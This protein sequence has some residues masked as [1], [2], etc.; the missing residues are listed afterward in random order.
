VSACPDASLGSEAWSKSG[1][2]LVLFFYNSL[3]HFPALKQ[4]CGSR[5]EDKTASDRVNFAIIEIK[6]FFCFSVKTVRD[7]LSSLV[8]TVLQ[9]RC[10][11]EKEELE[12]V[13]L[14]TLRHIVK[15]N[16]S[17]LYEAAFWRIHFCSVFP[18]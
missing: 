6:F 18:R 12:T 10:V 3:L 7:M 9:N 4:L 16:L 15:K 17:C 14:G 5:E 2:N 11:A 8:I 1:V 13:F